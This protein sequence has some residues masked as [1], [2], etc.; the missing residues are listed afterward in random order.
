MGDRFYD[1]VKSADFPQT[2]IRYSDKDLAKSLGLPIDDADWIKHFGRFEALADNLKEPL[3]LRYHGHQFRHYNPDLGDGRGFLFAQLYDGRGRLLDLGTKGS[4]QT[5]YSRRGDGRLTL[6]GGVREV[7]ATRYLEHMGMNTSR[8]MSLIETG[9]DLVRGDEPSPTR[10]A[11]MV[12]CNHSHI[13]FGTFQRQAFY[14]DRD[15]L[16]SLVD[17]C[18]RHFYSDAKD[19]AEMLEQVCIASADM[20]A[21]WMAAGFVHGVMNTDNMNI[22]GESFDYGPYRFLPTLKSGLT[23]AYFDHNGLYAFARQ[24]EI[25]YWNLAQL[26]Q[27]LS[28]IV[29][30]KAL[31]NA[32]EA[33][34]EAYQ[35]SLRDQVFRRLGLQSKNLEIDMDFILS[36]F[37]L[38]EKTQVSWPQ[39]WYDW[40]GGAPKDDATY[41]AEFSDWKKDYAVYSVIGDEPK[42]EMPASLIYEEIGELWKPIA[43]EDDWSAFKAKL[44]TYSR[45]D[46]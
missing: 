16:Q 17:Y 2:Q 7:L 12:R 9:E 34:A 4:G 19:G 3:A 30:D 27:S 29:E 15:A 26:A 22:T 41:G 24:P 28:L 25:M 5:P 35:K 31:L 20:V 33:F 44:D 6:L 11:V 23:A 45:A 14:E 21:G 43:K 42:A 37:R 36:T 18:I 1:P 10:S 8:T 13:R 46:F 39:F 40:Q 38:L 32:L